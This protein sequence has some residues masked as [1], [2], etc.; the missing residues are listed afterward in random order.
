MT[1][2]KIQQPLWPV[3]KVIPLLERAGFLLLRAAAP[4]S[5]LGYR[6][7]PR[8]THLQLGDWPGHLHAGD[9]REPLRSASP[10]RLGVAVRGDRLRRHAVNPPLLFPPV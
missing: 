4:V 2:S 10:G 6:F 9:G 5:C 3:S 7:L 8:P 1:S